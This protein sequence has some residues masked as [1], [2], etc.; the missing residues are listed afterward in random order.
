MDKQQREQSSDSRYL[1]RLTF[2]PELRNMWLNFFVTNFRVVIL[3]ILVVTAWGLYSFFTLPRESN[4]EVKIPIAIVT[5]PYPGASPSDVEEF[6]TKKIETKLSGLK[7]LE[8]ITSNSYNSISSIQ[9]EFDANLPTSEAIRDLRDKVADAKPDISTDAKDSIVTEISLDDAPIW[10]ISITGPYDGFTLHS[11]AEQI[12]D[13]L[14][15]IPGVREISISGGDVRQYEIAYLADR[16]TFYGLNVTQ[17][18]QAILGANLAIPG[19]NFEQGSFTFPIRADA[20]ST[21]VEGISNIPITH[22]DSGA[23][24][25]LHDVAN[26]RETAVK[27]TTYSRLS[28]NGSEPRNSVSLSL[29]KRQGASV[30]DTVDEAKKT[31]DKTIASFP[32]GITYNV[33]M[34]MAAEVKKSFDQLSHDFLITVILVAGILFLIVGL[35]EAFVAGLAIP[36]V[37]FVSFGVLKLMGITLNFLSLFSLIL[38]LGLLVDDAIVVVSATKQY[39]NTGKFTPE[40]A[41]LLVLNDFKWVLTTTTL[42]TVWAFLPLLFSTGIVGQYLRSIPITVSITL[43]ASL[44]IALMI[45]HPLAAVLERIRLTKRFF[46]LI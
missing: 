35:K 37:F 17:A 24:I 11:Y 45:N 44:F 12:Q 21:D 41:V 36:L 18:N 5:T 40:E 33:S 22:T 30:L 19:G 10:S 32:P 1:E 43:V 20:R 6:V 25:Y 14:E 3:L 7:G 23:T 31:V 13:E 4:P 34:D 46:Y 2:R 15:K 42:A 16:L 8:K 29:I 9:V 26:V 27:K 28:V 39:L 38:A